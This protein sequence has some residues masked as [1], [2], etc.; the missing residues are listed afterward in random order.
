[1][2]TPGTPDSQP[3]PVTVIGPE[4]S[5]RGYWRA[6][7]AYREL[8]WFL[9]RRDILVRFRQTAVGVLWLLIRPA[10][11]VLIYAMVF[12]HI[13]GLPSGGIA[14]PVLVM[15]GVTAWTLFAAIVN[16]S[17]IA[18]TNNINLITKVHFPRI[19]LPLGTAAANLV[20]LAINLLACLALM[21]V[22]GHSPSW[23]LLLLPLPV[24]LTM[25]AGL[26]LGIW[27]SAGCVRY[28][29]FRQITPF[30]LNVLYLLG[31]VGYA[32][33]V[34]HERLGPHAALFYY[35]NPLAGAIDLMRWCLFPVT[36][37]PTLHP[38]GLALSTGVAVIILLWAQRYFRHAEKTFADVI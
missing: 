20:D 33:A 28:R 11:Q 38:G 15:A 36:A 24:A 3:G 34:V 25:T 7:W 35:L 10:A 37:A 6:C 1:M 22:Y 32:T 27:F 21:M 16:E 9:A 5:A 17:T 13:A 2:T 12:G 18:L 8:L 26:G 23:R 4:G 29:D 19:L 30:L 14:Y 31:P